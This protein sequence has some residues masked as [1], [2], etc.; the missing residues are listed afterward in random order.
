MWAAASRHVRASIC[1]S[2]SRS[3]RTS[4]GRRCRHRSVPTTSTTAVS[5]LSPSCGKRRSSTMAALLSV[6]RT[7]A[8]RPINCSKTAANTTKIS[9]SMVPR[10]ATGG[11][12]N[13]STARVAQNATPNQATA[14]A[15][16]SS[17]TYW[18]MRRRSSPSTACTEGA[19]AG[20]SSRLVVDMCFV[21]VVVVGRRSAWDP[22]FR[23]SASYAA[24]QRRA[25]RF[26]AS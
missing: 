16:P 12:K 17:Q 21:D 13:Q 22:L 6:M 2:I 18:R 11:S 9:A 25:C 23:R 26:H 3:S 1:G 10:T 7:K 4:C 19:S 14:A 20:R 5:R 8:R 24:A 15:Q